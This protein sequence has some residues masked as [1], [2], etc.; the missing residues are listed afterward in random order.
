MIAQKR[1]R[2]VL[3]YGWLAVGVCILTVLPWGFLAIAKREPDFW[4]YFF[5]VEHIQ[6]FAEKDAQRK[7]LFWYYIPFLFA[8]SL[9]WPGAAAWALKRG[10]SEAR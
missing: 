7:A 1:W 4:R 2:E 8:G 10:W 3:T 5:W 6:R 9:P